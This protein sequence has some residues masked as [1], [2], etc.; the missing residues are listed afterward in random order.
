MKWFCFQ[1]YT[2]GV[3]DFELKFVQYITIIKQNLNVEVGL[4]IPG[5]VLIDLHTKSGNGKS[6]F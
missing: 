4:S 5:D 1:V 3:K 6:V 2:T